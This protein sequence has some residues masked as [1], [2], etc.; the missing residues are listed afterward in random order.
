MRHMRT[1]QNM[2][3]MA[4]LRED[5]RG[6]SLVEAL[7]ALLVAA[8]ATTLLV[9]MVMASTDIASTTENELARV[10][11]AQSAM[12]RTGN[13]TL[14]VHIEADG[15]FLDEGIPVSVYASED[16]SFTRYENAAG[17]GGGSS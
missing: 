6:D 11:D 9:T 17:D 14:R 10:Y 3:P 4:F 15:G 5:I 8:L 2:N 13:D 16:G 12:N 1:P 7:A